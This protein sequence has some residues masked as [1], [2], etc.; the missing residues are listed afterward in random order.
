MSYYTIHGITNTVSGGTSAINEKASNDAVSTDA[1][2]SISTE[3]V[4]QI[5]NTISSLRAQINRTTNTVNQYEKLP[6]QLNVLTSVVSSIRANAFKLA[7]TRDYSAEHTNV[8]NTQ[9]INNYL[10]TNIPKVW[11]DTN[12]LLESS[13]KDVYSATYIQNIPNISAIPTVYENTSKTIKSLRD[14]LVYS[15]SVVDEIAAKTPKYHYVRYSDNDN[16]TAVYNTSYINSLPI[17]DSLLSRCN[18]NPR[19]NDVYTATYINNEIEARIPRLVRGPGDVIDPDKNGYTAGYINSLHIPSDILY[20]HDTH[21]STSYNYDSTLND[22]YNTYYIDRLRNVHTFTDNQSTAYTENA[23]MVKL[24]DDSM[25]KQELSGKR[26]IQMYGHTAQTYMFRP[27]S[28]AL[29]IEYFAGDFLPD[30]E[31]TPLM[32]IT[33]TGAITFKN[34]VVGDY[35]E[36][37][38]PDED[39][40]MVT[41]DVSTSTTVKDYFGLS[42]IHNPYALIQRHVHRDNNLTF[43]YDID[44]IENGITTHALKL[45]PYFVK[46]LLPTIV[47]NTLAV[48][49]AATFNNTLNVTGTT[50]LNDKLTINA[51][52]EINGKLV[53]NSSDATALEVLTNTNAHILLGKS[54]GENN[55]ATIRYRDDMTDYLGFGFYGNDDIM[56]LYTDHNIAVTN[57]NLNMLQT[58]AAADQSITFTNDNDMARLRFYNGALEIATGDN[59]DEPICIQQY[60]GGFMTLVREATLLDENGN[61]QFPQTV[62][63]KHIEVID[64]TNPSNVVIGNAKIT[65]NTVNSND[66][67]SIGTT[68]ND[69]IVQ[70]TNDVIPLITFNDTSRL[71]I[72]SNA[73][74]H[75]AEF[76]RT[77]ATNVNADTSL[78]IGTA[79]AQ[80][81]SFVLRY[82]NNDSGNTQY[83]GLGYY[84]ND[85]IIRLYT[86][87]DVEFNDGNINLV[88]TDLNKDQQ[89]HFIHGSDDARIRFCDEGVLELAVADDGDEQ[90]IARKYHLETVV[91]EVKILDEN[92]NS[93]FSG[94][95]TAP[96][97]VATDTMKVLTP[98]ANTTSVTI[99]NEETTN[100]SA[101]ITYHNDTS[102]HSVTI[103]FT[104]N[105]DIFTV[106][107]DGTAH[108][109]NLAYKDV[110]TIHYYFT[111]LRAQSYGRIDVYKACKLGYVRTPNQNYSIFAGT[112]DVTINC[113][114]NIS[115]SFKAT[116]TY[117]SERTANQ[118]LKIDGASL[119]TNSLGQGAVALVQSTT[120]T[121][122]YA[123]YV[124][125]T[126]YYTVDSIGYQV[127]CYMPKDFKLYADEECTIAKNQEQYAYIIGQLPITTPFTYIYW[128]NDIH[129]LKNHSHDDT[130]TRIDSLVTPNSQPTATLTRTKY[131]EEDTNVTLTQDL[132]NPLVYHIAPSSGYTLYVND[133]VMS[134][135]QIDLNGMIITHANSSLT[136]SAS[137]VLNVSFTVML[138]RNKYW[139]TFNS[140]LHQDTTYTLNT[141]STEGEAIQ[142]AITHVSTIEN[143]LQ[144]NGTLTTTSDIFCEG[145][146]TQ[147]SDRTLKQ[148]IKPLA[149][150]RILDKVQTYSFTFIN[151]NNHNKHYGVIAQE[152]QELLPELVHENPRTHKLTVDYI[153]FIPHLINKVQQLDAKNKR[154]NIVIIS[155]FVL[156][157][158]FMLYI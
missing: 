134:S 21:E 146:V 126:G 25:H 61:T 97:F 41:R 1:D 36:S 131:V 23:L 114:S 78:A 64:T 148:D 9:Y 82:L 125:S 45:D 84:D 59:A 75:V 147:T 77:T 48:N 8:Y 95:V 122:V 24:Y 137:T 44:L 140:A 72:I 109:P 55:C 151:D 101:V 54:E 93:S 15:V 145:T 135:Q 128:N 127:R 18:L 51:N 20:T 152:L 56:K 49:N 32:Q 107:A 19:T 52:E 88:Q 29:S 154:Q 65:H 2:T 89:I 143:D 79:L 5:E 74:S 22:V 35:L 31:G 50:T 83:T 156:F 81:K 150:T 60:T 69:D 66:V 57:G 70:I 14:P 124:L 38:N 158:A 123:I 92:G 87:R 103:G 33:N 155:L 28:N 112:I 47:N 40:V 136:F 43:N 42:D 129:A 34:L 6:A 141:T 120:N 53:I 27:T 139:F 30:A 58:N 4:A 62:T 110:N 111:G 102:P 11:D 138:Q 86:S 17:P 121:N 106:K 68:S 26:R 130:Y 132:L 37:N 71:Q 94:N 67:V 90:I 142:C 3:K 10:D 98:S 115:E 133:T 73:S 39:I 63:S 108:A 119:S 16:S 117:G 105:E 46:T 153:E 104:D 85:D 144:V 76:I 116:L 113:T 118:V 7:A 100:N 12:R 99:G 157:V 96:Q 80:N 91:S 13:D 149:D